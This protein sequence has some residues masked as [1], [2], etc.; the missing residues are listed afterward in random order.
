MVQEQDD[1][2][3]ALKWIAAQLWSDGQVGM[4]GISWG[5]FQAI[6]AA[7]RSPPEHKAIIPASFAPDRYD[8]GQVFL[9]GRFLIRSVRWPSPLFGHKPR[10]PD[11]PTGG[12]QWRKS[13]A[14]CEGKRGADT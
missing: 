3:E 7:F 1:T 9:G 13:G 8:Y 2:L 11:P 14:L 10:T 5:G 6:Q 4:F 12:E